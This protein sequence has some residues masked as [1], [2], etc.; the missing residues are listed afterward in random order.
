M[1]GRQTSHSTAHLLQRADTCSPHLKCPLPACVVPLASRRGASCAKT[2]EPIEMPT[3]VTREPKTRADTQTTLREAS[4]APAASV[5][6]VRCGLKTIAS[7]A[8]AA[9]IY[10]TRRLLNA[11]R[12]TAALICRRRPSKIH[13]PMKV[14]EQYYYLAEYVCKV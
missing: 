9:L 6:C 12:Y 3:R 14:F 11:S 1:L 4:V 13:R 8:D 7:I 2:A 10:D 5:R